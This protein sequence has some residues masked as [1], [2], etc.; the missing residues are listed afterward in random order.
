MILGVSTYFYADMAFL[1]FMDGPAPYII[2]EGARFTDPDIST[3]HM[4]AQE[5]CEF[6]RR[7]VWYRH[8]LDVE[9]GYCMMARRYLRERATGAWRAFSQGGPA[10]TTTGAATTPIAGTVDT[11]ISATPAAPS[12]SA[13]QGSTA[14]PS[15]P[16]PP[17]MAPAPATSTGTQTT[18]AVQSF[19]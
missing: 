18:T 15:M 10:L 9:A 4:N 6:Q 3:A 7:A 8:I 2:G 17:T 11:G 12:T 13:A 1:S 14:A 19:C 5:M 16:P